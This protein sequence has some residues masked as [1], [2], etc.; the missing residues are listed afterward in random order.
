MDHSVKAS[1]LLMV[2]FHLFLFC[3]GSR[4]HIGVIPT[5]KL[6]PSSHKDTSG[7]HFV[8]LPRAV[9]IPPS[10]P[11]RRHNSIGL[12]HQGLH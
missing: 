9:P 5:M 1:V 11:S 8:T 10:G 2:L 6:P 3:N 7:F 4:E 12:K